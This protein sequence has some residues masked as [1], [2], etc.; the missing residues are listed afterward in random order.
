MNTRHAETRAF[1]MSHCTD[2]REDELMAIAQI[3]FC[4][5]SRQSVHSLC[6]TS[7]ASSRQAQQRRDAPFLVNSHVMRNVISKVHINFIS[8]VII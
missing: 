4:N 7:P 5:L 3:A 8:S 6:E 2:A 1:D